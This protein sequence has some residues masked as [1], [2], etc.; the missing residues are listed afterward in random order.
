VALLVALQLSIL[1]EAAK[2]R[3]TAALLAALPLL[4][5]VGAA[6][7]DHSSRNSPDAD[8]A[9]GRDRKGG[10]GGTVAGIAM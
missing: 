10:G 7:P 8:F 9:W 3:A 4:I 1:V 6:S 2:G 5:L